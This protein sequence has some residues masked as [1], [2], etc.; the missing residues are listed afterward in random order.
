MADKSSPKDLAP[1]KSSTASAAKA[2][3]DH[4]GAEDEI[5]AAPLKR[6][7]NIK[8]A[9]ASIPDGYEPAFTPVPPN[10]PNVNMTEVRARAARH[11]GQ[12]NFEAESMCSAR[13]VV[14]LQLI[15]LDQ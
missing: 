1:S 15:N 3:Q 6:V 5:K 4:E 11:K 13:Q 8:K 10:S 14:L 12:M 2:G 7:K 9:K